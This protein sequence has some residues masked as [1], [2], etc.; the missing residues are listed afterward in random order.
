MSGTGCENPMGDVEKNIEEIDTH[1]GKE[2][3]ETA[4]LCMYRVI[5]AWYHYQKMKQSLQSLHKAFLFGACSPMVLDSRP[6]GFLSQVLFTPLWV[7][8]WGENKA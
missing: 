5:S 4:Y 2:A 1:V 8:S 3:Q 6:F 7:E